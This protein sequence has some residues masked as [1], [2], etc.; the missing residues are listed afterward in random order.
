MTFIKQLDKKQ[1]QILKY[2]NDPVAFT[3]DLL[4]LKCEDFHQEWLN[5]F[6]DNR[7]TLLLAPRGHGKTSLVGSYILWRIVRNRRL[8][9]IIVTINQDKANAMMTFI[10]ENLENNDRLKRVFGD[11]KGPLWSRNEIRVKQHAK[12]KIPHNE[13]TL[14]VLGVGSRI[15]SG[16]YELIVLDDITDDENSHTETRRRNLESWYNKEV[17]GTFLANSKVI[18][19]G[20]RWHEDDIHNYF[21]NKAGFKTLVYKALLNEQEVNDGKPAKVLWPEHLPWDKNMAKEYNLSETTLT[22]Q[23]IREHQGELAFQMQYQNNIIPAGIAKFKAEWLDNAVNNY[24]KHA[25]SGPIGM[26]KYMG[27]D[28]GGEDSISDWCVFTVIGIDSDGLI[29]TVEQ[30]RTHASLQRQID[31]IRGLDE[32]HHVSRIGIETA[33]QQKLIAS[34]WIKNNP[35]LPIMTIKSSRANDKET[36]TDRLSIMFETNRIC[37]D[38]KLIHLIDELKLY[39]RAKHDDCIDSLSFAI[40]SAQDKGFIDWSKATDTIM[41]RKR[42]YSIEVI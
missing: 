38:P 40:E 31:I 6:N 21:I 23:F 8:R 2:A 41:T 34:D 16:H 24:R 9:C 22:L 4:G 36:R 12:G 10:Q 26:R 7:F 28:I 30:I 20:T 3:T 14:K 29:Y 18:D 25:L 39:P 37:L 33:A 42:D 19:I 27:V 11:F 1:L 15:I 5:A 32:K 13:P 35:G 17:V